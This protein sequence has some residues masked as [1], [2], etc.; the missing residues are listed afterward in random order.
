MFEVQES[1]KNGSRFFHSRPCPEEGAPNKVSFSFF[2]IESDDIIS[3][4]VR[5]KSKPLN[6]AGLRRRPVRPE[7]FWPS[8]FEKQ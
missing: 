2:A 7:V 1:E 5:N 4:Q 6:T 8:L 3:A